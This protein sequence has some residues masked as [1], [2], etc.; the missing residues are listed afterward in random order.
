MK[1]QDLFIKYTSLRDYTGSEE[2]V[3]AQTLATIFSLDPE[4]TFS[5]LEK[6]ESS[7]KK[8]AIKEPKVDKDVDFEY[9]ISDVILV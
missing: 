3:Y 4:E 9:A 7:S 5:L 1:G 8:L 6:A 2:D